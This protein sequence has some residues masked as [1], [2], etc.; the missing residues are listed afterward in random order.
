MTTEYLD[1]VGAKH[2][3]DCCKELVEES[4]PDLSGYAPSNHNHDEAYQPKG[5]YVTETELTAKDFA[6][7]P[8]VDNAIANALTSGEVD[9]SNYYTKAQT[10]NKEEIDAKIPT[11]PTNVSAFVNDSGYLTEHQSLVGYATE[12]FVT[13]KIAAIPPTDLSGYYTKAEVDALIASIG[14]GGT[15]YTVTVSN[16]GNGTASADVTSATEG[17]VVTLTNTP[18]DGYTFKEWQVVSGNITI[19]DNKFTMPASNVEVKAVFEASSGG[20][21][22]TAEI[23]GSSELKLSL[24][25]TYTATFKDASGNEVTDVACTWNVISDYTV[26]QSVN[27]NQIELLYEDDTAIGDSFLLDVLVGGTVL[28]EKEIA[29]ADF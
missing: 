1:S 20:G 24:P 22:A 14:G 15:T 23:S 13:E 9:L 28:A 2:I 17:T 27:G 19:A 12:A 16:D 4:A 26:E 29:F 21:V 5:D 10:Y 6:D 18:N 25:R 11:V 7:K 8:Y 3:V